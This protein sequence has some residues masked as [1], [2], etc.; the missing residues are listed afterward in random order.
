MYDR[1]GLLV[2]C[3][4][5]GHTVYC[6]PNA[7]SSSAP[8]LPSASPCSGP[9][10][11]VPWSLFLNSAH[12]RLV[13]ELSPLTSSVTYVSKAL[14]SGSVPKSV[15]GAPACIM[16]VLVLPSIPSHSGNILPT[17][18]RW[19]CLETFLVV[20]TWE[21]G[22]YWCL[23][24][25]GLEFPK[26]PTEYRAIPPKKG[27]LRHNVSNTDVEKPY[28]M[29]FRGAVPQLNSLSSSPTAHATVFCGSVS[30]PPTGLAPTGTHPCVWS[31]CPPQSRS[32]NTDRVSVT[33]ALLW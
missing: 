31:T 21:R 29:H 22:C 8:P 28:P 15:F 10:G 3:L 17:Q 18:D 13:M 5:L 16:S 9:Q 11:S 2:I 33:Q 24:G 25:S 14:E 23:A 19:E 7:L 4:F 12:L 30:V 26:H 6:L 20:T 1:T 32:R 27:S